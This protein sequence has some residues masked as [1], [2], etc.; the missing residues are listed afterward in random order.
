MAADGDGYVSTIGADGAE[1]AEKWVAG[2]NAPRGLAVVAGK[3]YTSDLT[4]LVEIDIA[5][6]AVTNRFPA[7]GSVLLNDVTAAPDGRIF[8]SDTFGNSVWVLEG[9]AMSIFAQDPALMGANGLTVI[10][11]ALVVANLGDASQGFDKI[12]PGWVVSIGPKA[13]RP[14]T[15]VRMVF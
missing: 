14:Q 15:L 13:R 9:G 11:N 8:V 2:L 12:K 5:T 10:G 6:A 7:P 1:I 3:L 4:A